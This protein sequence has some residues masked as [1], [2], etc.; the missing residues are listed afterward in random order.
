MPATYTPIRY[1]GGKT[2]IYPL[3]KKIIDD[4]G[5]RSYAYA[6]AFAGGA[7]LAMKLLL[8][9]DVPSVIINDLDRA[10]YCMWDAIVN[11]SED[12]C[13]FVSDVEV[14]VDEWKRH[15][16]TYRSQKDVDDFELG[17]A[18]FFLNRTNVSG[19]LDGGVIGGMEQFGNFKI[20]ARFSKPGLLAKIRAIG[21][22]R[23]D[24][25]IFNLD[26]ETFIVDVLT[27]EE[28]LFAYFDPPYVKKGPGLYRSSFDEDKHR[29]LAKAIQKCKF[30][31]IATYDDDELIEKL[32][33]KNVR[34]TFGIG[35]S[36]YRASRGKEKL[37]L[38]PNVSYSTAA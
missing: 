14:T 22:R 34:E 31:W 20:D 21:K 27:R 10:V 1:P 29:S 26:A 36:A 30:P 19:I 2:K 12:L 38:P 18:A 3:V 7:G 25:R 9:G 8:K 37:I 28:S 4:N 16:E 6:E 24:I 32:Y 23:D 15:R 13:T 33:G 11:R 17:C 35:Y 5:F